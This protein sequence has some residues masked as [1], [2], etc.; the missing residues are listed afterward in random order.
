GSDDSPAVRVARRIVD[1]AQY[2]YI[3]RDT[4]LGP[5]FRTPGDLVIYDAEVKLQGSVEGS[6][7]VLGGDF[8]IRPGGRVGGAIAVL[9]G[10]VYPSALAILRRDSIF[11]QEPRTGVATRTVPT[12][13]G[14]GYTAAVTVTPPP[15]A[16]FFAPGYGPLPSYDR[17]NGV[18][19]Y[20]SGTIR[21]T[22]DEEGPSIRVF[23]AYRFRNENHLGGGA[24]FRVPL[25]TQNLELAGEVSRLHR[26]NDAW[27]RPDFSNTVR[28]A[29]FGDDER[30][31]WDSDLLRVQVQRPVGIPLITGESWVG[32]RVGFQVSRDRSLDERD[33]PSLFGDGLNRA[34]PPVLE[35]TIVSGLLGTEYHWRGTTSRVDG[36]ADLEVAP[37]GVGDAS[38][39]QGLVQGS[40]QAV[41][42]RTH[43]MRVYFRG[44]A[45]LSGDAP[46]QREGILGGAATLA[47]E[48]TASFRGDHL[49]FIESSYAVPINRI[50][51]PYVGSP[52][53]EAVHMVGAAWS[54]DHSPP[55]VQNAGV[56]VVFTLVRARILINP[57]N[58]G[59]AFAF[60]L[61]L[62]QR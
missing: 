2:V 21:P 45:P 48:P 9:D 13:E 17:V 12:G 36:S 31:Y 28:A 57:A 22:R 29:V 49:V 14:G 10:G 24:R 53:I 47:T 30:D 52:S 19:L 51:L 20:A 35:G 62:P 61:S 16:P 40:Y 27:I 56:G 8:W 55:W 43:T 60:G 59:T 4:V 38:F 5:D 58:G 18:T 26:T 50:V 7:A 11:Q 1:R 44:M 41:A 37:G 32:P 3:D 15:R 33:P 42:L 39:S 25:G 34:N 23:G 54:G 46:P 6:V